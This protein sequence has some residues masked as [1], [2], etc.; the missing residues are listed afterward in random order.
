[1]GVPAQSEMQALITQVRTPKLRDWEELRHSWMVTG[2]RLAGYRAT[3]GHLL[4]VVPP[5]Y[6]DEM[7]TGETANQVPDRN[8]SGCLC[9]AYASL[10]AAFHG[11][12]LP[13]AD[14]SAPS[15]SADTKTAAGHW[16]ASYRSAILLAIR[17][18]RCR[19][20]GGTRQ[21]RSRRSAGRCPAAPHYQRRRGTRDY[22]DHGVARM[23]PASSPCM[24]SRSPCG[25]C[26]AH[27]RHREAGRVAKRGP[28]AGI[29][30]AVLPV[31]WWTTPGRTPWRRRCAPPATCCCACW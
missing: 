2:P 11:G 27:R 4:N 18:S 30:W 21:P 29:V 31:T 16:A 10:R 25:N 20:T 26:R 5:S 14:H 17:T 13:E 24:P 19:R 15:A 9:R 22:Y 28:A 6:G 8:R 23:K 1:M 3:A 7:R 12:R